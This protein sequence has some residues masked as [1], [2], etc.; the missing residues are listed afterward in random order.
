MLSESLK[1]T[2]ISIVE[3]RASDHP[4]HL[5]AYSR[6]MWPY[7]LIKIHAGE[8]L[9]QPSLV[10]WPKSVEEVSLILQ[11]L[12]EEKI[13]L[14]P[15]GGGS[16]VCGGAVIPE[17]GIVIDM[18]MM[19]K[20]KKIDEESM[21]V[22]VEAGINGERFERYLEEKGYTLG[23]FP[24]SIYCSTP[25]GWVA[26]RS[27]GQLST[28]YGKI[29]DMVESLEVVLP[30]GKFLS[31]KKKPKSAS[32]P[33]INQIF[34]GSEG[35]L[36]II[37][38]ITFRIHRNPSMRKFRGIK[39]KEVY[40]GISAIKTIL[41][42]G[43][44]PSAVRLY[45]ELD[46]LLVASDLKK[47]RREREGESFLKTIL[48]R[49]QRFALSHP[50]LSK[51]LLTI[52]PS[53]CL[54]ILAFDGDEEKIKYELDES[55]RICREN[56]GVDLGEK[57]GIL[58]WQDRYKVSYNMSPIFYGGAFVDTIEVSAPWSKLNKLYDEMRRAISKY[59]IV[60]AHFSH[61]YSD[62]CSIY[63]T[64]A[65]SGE[66]AE[67][68]LKKY[69]EIWKSAMEACIKQGG[70]ISHHHGVGRL[71]SQWIKD[72]LREAFELLMEI[73]KT[74]DPHFIMNPGAMGLLS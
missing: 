45:D 59:A 50:R 31:M 46:T 67:E 64:F 70:S 74:I 2:L 18:K 4:A 52:L 35:T 44:K 63:F 43:I 29:E 37:T 17:G 54:L 8:K 55:L 65:G 22:D 10:L 1:R 9:T 3:G 72:E 69:T 40:D 56:E 5:R 24:S 11:K 19:E 25:G 20:I 41:Q 32:G 26:T 60:L 47:E 15:Y 7:L 33:D 23:H 28:L 66:N 21:L 62:G 13:P 49:A 38:S 53:E 30:S 42:K 51:S 14:L 68:K 61:A 71:K 58:W 39:F 48:M 16:G 6:D 34:I 27:A 36:G 12:N 57:P 73:K